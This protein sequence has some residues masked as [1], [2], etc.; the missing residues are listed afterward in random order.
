MI[1][2]KPRDPLISNLRREGWHISREWPP[3]SHHNRVVFWPK[4]ERVDDVVEQREAIRECMREIYRS[5][6]WAVFMDE[7][8][9]VVKFLGLGPYCE[10]L[11]Q[12]GRSLNVSLIGSTQRPKFVPL[13]AYDQATHL[14]LFRDS[15][16]VNLKRLGE[17]SGVNS[18]AVKEVV[19][20]LPKH[21]VL[22]VNTRDG[23]LYVT[24]APKYG[25]GN[26]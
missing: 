4:I 3:A 18:R 1:A 15:D 17:I 14:F 26:T 11:W 21:D 22:Y 10:L 25:R 6:G 8:A 24:R 16:A 23:E 2:C 20:R 5:G 7:L 19:S 13:A 9:Y 12:Q